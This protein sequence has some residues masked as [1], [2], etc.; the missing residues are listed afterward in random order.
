MKKPVKYQAAGGVVV[1]AKGDRVLLL[2]RPHRPG[3]DGQPEVRL[4]KGH[5]EPGES[6]RETALR[7]VREEAGLGELEIVADLGHQTIEFDWQGRHYVR[8]EFY[9]LMR[10]PAGATVAPP[11]D[12]F[13][14]LWLPWDEAL[15]RL[16]FQAEKE[17]LR[18]AITAH[19]R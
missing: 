3:P 14:R 16:T 17:W 18:R 7:E 12:Q 10:L 15:A 2:L 13:E 5:I 11:E 19:R 8:D 4:P 6:R 1:N 9:F